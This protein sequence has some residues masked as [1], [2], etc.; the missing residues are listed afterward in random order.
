AA[1]DHEASL[2]K[3]VGRM[4]RAGE[5]QR[6]TLHFSGPGETAKKQTAAALAMLSGNRL[7]IVNAAALAKENAQKRVCLLLSAVGLLNALIYVPNAD[8]DESAL[9]VATLLANL[10]QA[11]ATVVLSG[12]RKWQRTLAAP[13][14]IVDIPFTVP[15]VA[16]RRELWHAWLANAEIEVDDPTLDLLASR[17]VL[18][19]DQIS[20]PV[21]TPPTRV[22]SAA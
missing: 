15:G 19:A 8:A 12:A 21:P 14:G 20:D 2:S 22:A 11:D 18:T 4:A 13:R 5:S 17:F 9:A 7:L 10:E 3:F 1:W 16:A 6:L